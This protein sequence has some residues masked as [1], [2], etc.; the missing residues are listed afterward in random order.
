MRSHFAQTK[1]GWLAVFGIGPREALT[2]W[3]IAL[4]AGEGNYA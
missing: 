2:P 4:L 3:R 1:I